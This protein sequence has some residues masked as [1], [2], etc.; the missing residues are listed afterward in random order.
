[1]PAGKS[2]YQNAPEEAQPYGDRTIRVMWCH[3]HSGERPR[4][5]TAEQRNPAWY[6]DEH[7]GQRYHRNYKARKKTSPSETDPHLN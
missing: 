4:E 2:A 5:K 7:K 6:R 1:M 3:R